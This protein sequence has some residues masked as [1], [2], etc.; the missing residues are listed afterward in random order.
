[1]YSHTLHRA[2]GV[3]I[4][5]PEKDEM[6]IGHSRAFSGIVRFDSSIITSHLCSCLSE[7][8]SLPPPFCRAETGTV[9]E[10]KRELDRELPFGIMD[11]EAFF[12]FHIHASSDLT[13]VIWPS[14]SW[15]I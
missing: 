8:G 4:R 14:S 13:A 11:S 7:F 6:S 12:T 2:P 15:G 3:E 1:M 10:D 5:G 9:S